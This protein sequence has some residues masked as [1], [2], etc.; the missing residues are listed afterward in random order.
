MKTTRVLLMF[1]LATSLFFVSCSEENLTVEPIIEETAIAET[2]TLAVEQKSSKL[3]DSNDYSKFKTSIKLTFSHFEDIEAAKGVLDKISLRSVDGTLVE[4]YD[5]VEEFDFLDMESGILMDIAIVPI[6]AGEY[7][8]AIVHMV[9]AGVTYKGEEY[10]CYVPGENMILSFSK[11]VSVVTVLSQDLLL[12]IDVSESFIPLYGKRK[13]KTYNKWTHKKEAPTPTA[14]IFRPVVKTQNLT[15]TGSILVAAVTP[16]SETEVLGVGGASIYLDG[17]Y[18]GYET[19]ETPITDDRGNTLLDVGQFIIPSLPPGETFTVTL[20]KDG[21]FD[22]EATAE[23]IEGN[24][25]IT[26][27]VMWPE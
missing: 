7:T 16:I 22:A 18:I 12:D 24:F 19:L 10:D 15:S 9:S 27:I 17:E 20:K 23:I 6:P 14:F 26:P 4:I 11:P 1:F 13:K 2:A 3:N 25:A 21:F 5:Q 8:E